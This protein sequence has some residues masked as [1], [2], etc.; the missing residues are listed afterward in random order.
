MTPFSCL[1][2]FVPTSAACAMSFATSRYARLLLSVRPS[3]VSKVVYVFNYARDETDSRASH[4]EV[5]ELKTDENNS[6]ISHGIGS[7]DRIVTREGLGSAGKSTVSSN[8]RSEIPLGFHSISVISRREECAHR[9]SRNRSTFKI[10]KRHDVTLRMPRR[11]SC[12]S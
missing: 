3:F 2:L 11:R 5:L 7:R 6:A 10:L 9:P 12:R 1:F 8:A 4:E